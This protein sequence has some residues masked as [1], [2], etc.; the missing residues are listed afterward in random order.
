VTRQGAKP[1]GLVP[2][3]ARGSL[4]CL[5]RVDVVQEFGWTRHCAADRTIWFKGHLYG[6]FRQGV[7]AAE[8]LARSFGASDPE[9]F[10]QVLRVLD[11]HFAIIVEAPDWTLA[12]VDRV[13]TIPLFFGRAAS[14]EWRIDSIAR[15]LFARLADQAFD[16]DGVFA[17]AMAGFTTGHRT[18]YRGLHSL[19]SGE[20][21]LFRGGE[22]TRRRWYVYRPW[23]AENLE[24]PAAL[25]QLKSV[26]LGLFEKVRDSLAGR[27]V[28][29][30]LSA[31]LDS[32]LVVSALHHL[33]YRDVTCLSYGQPGNHETA[34]A[35]PVAE[36]LGF[37][38]VY[39][40]STLGKLRAYFGSEAHRRYTEFADTFQSVPTEQDHPIISELVSGGALSAETVVIN[41]QSGDYITGGHVARSLMST[42]DTRDPSDTAPLF[43]AL[44][45]KHFSLWPRLRTPDNDRRLAELLA[46]DLRAADAPLGATDKLWALYE[47]SEWQ[48]RQCKH[49]VPGQR[50]YEL[51]GLDW[52]LPLWDN[53]FTEFWERMPRDLKANQN[54]Y[55]ELLVTE[56]WGGVWQGFPVPGPKY[57][58]PKWI[59][60]MRLLGK[61]LCAPAGKEFWHKMERR[62]FEYRMGGL[63]LH[64]AVPYWRVALDPRDGGNVMAWINELY[65]AKKGLA[66]D[67]VA[68]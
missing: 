4:P 61:I 48:D 39:V 27:P 67:G 30:P 12:A 52:R 2:T 1:A 3:E 62:F 32:R 17:F 42:L 38:F 23:L 28:L 44:I 18:L 7:T 60:P 51:H 45:A 43:Q 56:N 59:R 13:Q 24:R 55:R 15:R 41:G 21:V 31:G 26:T 65:L 49:V 9:D 40:P 57:V 16:S 11:G 25:R 5:P 34:V 29:V 53:M 54:L 50:A 36:R 35:R 66:W 19:L 6:P 8:G 68:R 10:E 20:M 22:A 47:L 37:R 63:C 14:G 46:G 58:V 64:A 33:G